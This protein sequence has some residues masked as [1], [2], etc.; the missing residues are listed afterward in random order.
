MIGGRQVGVVGVEAHPAHEQAERYREGILPLT[1]AMLDA[2]RAS[3]F[4]GR[5]DFSTVIEDFKLW[6]EARVALARREAERFAARAEFDRL[7]GISGV[8]E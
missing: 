5:G 6:L 3:Y 7:S 4:T 8:K 2:A 1:S